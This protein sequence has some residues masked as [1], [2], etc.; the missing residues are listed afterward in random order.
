MFEIHVTV[1]GLSVLDRIRLAIG[2]QPKRVEQLLKRT[3]E[4]YKPRIKATLAVEP[5]LR[6]GRIVWTSNAQRR[7][8]VALLR[9][10]ARAAGRSDIR[11]IRTHKLSRGYDVEVVPGED[12]RHF[13]IVITHK[14]RYHIY[15]KWKWQQGFHKKTGWQRDEVYLKVVQEEM[16]QDFGKNVVVDFWEAAR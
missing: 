4:K 2:Q 9:K 13:G 3:S 8:V 16:A 12:V 15:V 1:R 5:P 7:T 11:Y 6:Q 14:E 10:R